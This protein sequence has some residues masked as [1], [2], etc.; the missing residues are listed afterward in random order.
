MPRFYSL[1]SFNLISV[2]VRKIGLAGRKWPAIE[3]WL[4][5]IEARPAY[6]QTLEAAGLHDF[7]LLDLEKQG[8]I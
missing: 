5:H 4:K 3:R 7:S 6:R 8:K 1:A 2:L